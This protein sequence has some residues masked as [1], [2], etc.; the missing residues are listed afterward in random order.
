MILL[1]TTVLLYAV[2][3]EHSL[4]EPC[5]RILAAHSEGRI[6]ATTTVEVVQEFVHVRARRRTRS[7]AAALGRSWETAFDLLSVNSRDLDV[8]LALFEQHEELGAFDSL[9][10]GVA[11]NRGLDGLISAD[12]AFGSVTGLRWINPASR[13]LESLL[14]G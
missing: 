11:L 8:G 12:R 9:L 2:G 1:D 10:A 3:G 14:R 6:E 5:R 7:D 13:S 4:R